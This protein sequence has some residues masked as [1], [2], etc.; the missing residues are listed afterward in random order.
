MEFSFSKRGRGESGRGF[1]IDSHIPFACFLSS[2]PKKESDP[3]MDDAL[4]SFSLPEHPSGVLSQRLHPAPLPGSP[5]SGNACSVPFT[6]DSAQ[7]WIPAPRIPR[8][9]LVL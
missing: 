1:S 8:E 2:I 7:I 4:M 3:G 5:R 6:R 9:L